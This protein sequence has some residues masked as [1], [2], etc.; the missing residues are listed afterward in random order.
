[1]RETYVSNLVSFRVKTTKL[2]PFYGSRQK[3]EIAGN[4]NREKDGQGD[5]AYLVTQLSLSAHLCARESKTS[6]IEYESDL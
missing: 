2:R 5:G 3:D 1:M 4:G 6:R